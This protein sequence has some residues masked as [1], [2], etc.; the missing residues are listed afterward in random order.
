MPA[1]MSGEPTPVEKAPSAPYV[2]VWES[3]PMMASPG[4]TRPFS[5]KRACS[6]PICPTS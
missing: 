6:T 5:G 3:A 1:A 2:Q 4:A